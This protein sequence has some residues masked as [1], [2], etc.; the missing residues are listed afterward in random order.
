MKS[1]SELIQIAGTGVN[2]VIDA[3]SRTTADIINIIGSVGAKGSLI[4]IKN[5]NSRPTADLILMAN[6]YPKSITF[7][8][9]EDSQM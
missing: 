9:T 5:I 8:F 4:T 3:K 2:L 6:I 1:T 7:D